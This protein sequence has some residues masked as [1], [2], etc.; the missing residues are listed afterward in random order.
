MADSDKTCSELAAELATAPWTGPN[1]QRFF[2]VVVGI[3]ND[4]MI[5]GANLALRAG[6]LYPIKPQPEDFSQ[7]EEAIDLLGRD[8]LLLRYPGESA[9]ALR[10]RV[11][12]KWAFW[13]QGIKPALLAELTAAGY[14][15]AEIFVPNDFTPRPDPVDYWSRF[16]VFFP[17]GTHPVTSPTGFVMGTDIVGTDFIGPVGLNTP[18]GAEYLFRLKSVIRRMKPAQW[19]C[20]D[21]V[22]EIT[23]GVQYVHLQY[24]PRFDDPLYEYTNDGTDFPL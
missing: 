5:E 9:F 17:A 24:R 15:G 22:F 7:P 18:A 1:G 4:F 20:W 12:D 8:A 19:V 16:W 23:V 14:A 11:R 6:F 2:N 10:A 13:T 21:L 3:A